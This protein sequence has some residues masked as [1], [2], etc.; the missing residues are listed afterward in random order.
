MATNRDSSGF[1][2]S[3]LDWHFSE[4]TGTPFWLRKRESLGFD[5]RTDVANF[6]DLSRFPDCSD[7]LRTTAIEDL[8]PHGLA[9]KLTARVFESG[10]TTGAPKFVVAYDQW[11]QKLVDWRVGSYIDRTNRPSGNTLAAVPSGPH[12]VGAINRE[13]AARLGG[14]CFTI[15]V[16]PRWAK[17][18]A[19]HSTTASEAYR[20]HLVRQIESIVMT[21]DIRFLVTTPPILTSV[22]SQERLVERL[23]NTLAH[24]TLGGTALNIDTIRYV[25]AQ[26]LPDCEFSASYGSTSA[27]GESH[28]A[29]LDSATRSVAYKS[30]A[31]YITYEVV[32]DQG[33]PTPVGNRGNVRVSH[34]SPFAFYP[35]IHERDTAVLLGTND[36]GVG[37]TV[38]DIA[39]IESVEG[40]TVVEGV[41]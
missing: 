5:P 29:L 8:I 27:L 3:V 19:S 22:L 24:V 36:Y 21:Q 9:N 38:A 26:L 41:Y 35:N 34:L 25:A 32:D 18:A 17:T 10:G 20:S 39:P 16:D 11:I 4:A 15:D 28:S 7:E 14:L 6:S 31:P 1:L 30:F 12:I 33:E 13:R 23:R 37:A 40:V 2:R